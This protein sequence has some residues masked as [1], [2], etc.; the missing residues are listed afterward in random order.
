MA[1]TRKDAVVP[2]ALIADPRRWT[3][4]GVNYV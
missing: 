4:L 1:I 2:Y 3:L